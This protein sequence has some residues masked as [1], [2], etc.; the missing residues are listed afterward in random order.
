M[1]TFLN[2]LGDKKKSDF[3]LEKNKKTKQKQKQ[4]QR[5]TTTKF[6]RIRT[7]FNKSGKNVLK[8]WGKSGKI[9]GK[10]QVIFTFS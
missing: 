5:K 2:F 10:F 1:P 8:I 3:T 9:L 4:K 7:F 6:C